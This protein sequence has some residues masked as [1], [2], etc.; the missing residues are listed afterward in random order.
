MSTPPAT[1]DDARL[2][3]RCRRGMLELDLLLQGF[4]DNGYSRLDAKQKA[5]FIRLLELPDQVLLETLMG[6]GAEEE[7]EFQD[8]IARIRAAA[9]T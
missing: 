3:W 4:L 9:A 8:V 1:T 6:E 7:K 2:R 5:S